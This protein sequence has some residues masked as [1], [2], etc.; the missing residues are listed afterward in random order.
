MF[1]HQ[2]ILYYSFCKKNPPFA[3]KIGQKWHF[4]CKANSVDTLIYQLIKRRC[5][6]GKRRNPWVRSSKRC[7]PAP[8]LN[9]SGKAY[10]CEWPETRSWAPPSILFIVR[11][12]ETNEDSG[13]I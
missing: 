8:S 10:A 9:Q 11:F 3:R 1:N 5:P 4:S 13:E 2:K 6:T 7:K 12:S